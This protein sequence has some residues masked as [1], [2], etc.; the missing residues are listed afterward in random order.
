MASVK[1][2]KI[3]KTLEFLDDNIARKNSESITYVDYDTY[4]YNDL[5]PIMEEIMKESSYKPYDNQCRYN[6]AFYEIIRFESALDFEI[7]LIDFSYS[8]TVNELIADNVMPELRNNTGKIF[9]CKYFLDRILN[10]TP[11]MYLK[12]DDKNYIRRYIVGGNTK[13]ISSSTENNYL[14]WIMKTLIN[15]KYKNDK[16]KLDLANKQMFVS[17]SNEN[18]YFSAL[19]C[20]KHAEKTY[21]YIIES[22]RYELTNYNN[23]SNTVKLFKEHPSFEKLITSE[24]L[25]KYDY[26]SFENINYFNSDEEIELFIEA[27]NKYQYIHEELCKII[28]DTYVNE[29]YKISTI[30]SLYLLCRYY[31]YDMNELAD[32]IISLPFA[33]GITSQETATM[34]YTL[35]LYGFVD[36]NNKYPSN[37]S[38]L[39]KKYIKRESIYSCK[40]C[41]AIV[42]NNECECPICGHKAFNESYRMRDINYLYNLLGKKNKF[43]FTK[44]EIKN[45][46][47]MNVE[48]FSAKKS[49]N[50]RYVFIPFDRILYKMV[51]HE[52]NDEDIKNSDLFSH[53]V[54]N[55]DFK[56][57]EKIYVKKNGR[58]YNNISKTST[59]LGELNNVINEVLSISMTKNEIVSLYETPCL[60]LLYKTKYKD[61]VPHIAI[62][63]DRIIGKHISNDCSSI[64]EIFKY[65]SKQELD[66]ALDFY[67]KY[68]GCINRFIF[69]E[70]FLDLFFDYLDSEINKNILTFNQKIEIYSLLNDYQIKDSRSS[71]S[72]IVLYRHLRYL[73]NNGYTFTKLIKYIKYNMEDMF[74]NVTDVLSYLEDYRK[75][76]DLLN[77]TNDS[78]V[79]YDLYPKDLIL[80]HD[81]VGFMYTMHKN[82][83]LEH[84]FEKY[85]IINKE[86]EYHPE[87]DK[88]II[89]SPE[90]TE[91]LKIEGLS[92]SHC[93]GTYINRYAEGRSKIFFMRKVDNPTVPLIT[94]E[95]DENNALIQARG[96][97][98]RALDLIE[99]NFLKK[100]LK[101][102]VNK[103]I[104]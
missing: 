81:R 88:Y 43:F 8:N 71:T 33:Q 29:F 31:G 54:I 27:I 52:L 39:N 63:K 91:D 53:T 72:L 90:K 99:N 83:I 104:A 48:Y 51:R 3:N 89:I 38:S 10:S 37:L 86:Y 21:R 61:I 9:S 19:N 84:S 80:S 87:D 77:F 11:I 73:F 103:K 41:N 6:N 4:Y 7:K 56:N 58:K 70:M 76:L 60:E 49:C 36:E 22:G 79:K 62:N 35:N 78:N 24:V 50:Y 66:M 100:W 93:V 42:L 45:L 96:K 32:Y 44:I 46:F 28:N 68:K 30:H 95:L 15:E 92:L 102:V 18:I 82:E 69:D 5:R 34:L 13:T 1:I 59:A 65:R 98:N 23:L 16:E 94:I 20:I 85:A 17:T 47:E 40:F 64:K 26:H 75:T 14:V 2:D 25:D 57:D 55:I 101:T 97:H 67:N 12:I 74:Y